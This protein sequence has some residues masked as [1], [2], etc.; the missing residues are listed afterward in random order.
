MQRNQFVVVFSHSNYTIYN[1]GVEKHIREL[2]KIYI[3]NNMEYFH[4]FPLKK[5]PNLVGFNI[6][7]RF[8]GI[9]NIENIKY[10]ISNYISEGHF[11]NNILLQHIRGFDLNLLAKELKI[12]N[13]KI[14]LC[15]H[16]F[17][18]LCNTFNFMKNGKEFCGI[19]VP[20]KEKCYGCHNFPEILGFVEDIEFIL[21]NIDDNIEK[22][23]FPSEFCR[24]IWCEFFPTYRE[25]A[26]V[27]PLLD[28]DGKYKRMWNEKIRIAYVGRKNIYKGYDTWKKIVHQFYGQYDLY[29]FGMDTED[30]K[31]CKNIY[32]DGID[33]I[34]LE[35]LRKNN[36][37]I[38]LLWSIIPETYS[39]TYYECSAAGTVILSNINSGNIAEQIKINRNGFLFSSEKELIENMKNP[40]SLKNK[41]DIQC[42]LFAPLYLLPNNNIALYLSS[43]NN[44]VLKKRKRIHICK[45]LSLLY[46]LKN[47]M[48]K[49]IQKY[50]D[51]QM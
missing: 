9:V 32:V 10:I 28:L 2:E 22:V 31:A 47:I 41:I 45:V 12:I 14:I 18:Y 8:K 42:K 5:L 37:D 44:N 21:K 48:F 36:I 4:F 40:D 50:F 13:S 24:D 1:A 46:Y 26:Y 20:N 7:G 51:K 49:N 16:D 17:Y 43:N 25:R 6:N 33:K 3:E 19:S 29:Y 11:L 27:R 15:I 39:F 34:M 35:E 23:I 38:V 30:E